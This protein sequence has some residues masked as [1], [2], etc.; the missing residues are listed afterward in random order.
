MVQSRLDKKEKVKW[1]LEEE[2]KSFEL[3]KKCLTSPILAFPDF[4]KVILFTDAS[5]YGLGAVFIADT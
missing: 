2:E 3:L 5:D 4:K 1:G